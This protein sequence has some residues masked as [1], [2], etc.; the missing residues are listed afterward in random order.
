MRKEKDMFK[1]AFNTLKE[2]KFLFEELVK[3]DF[4]KKYKRTV[5]GMVWS[6]LGPLA[7]LGVM[8]LVFTHFFGRDIEH[9][10]IYILRKPAVRLFQRVHQSRH[11]IFIRKLSH[12]LQSQCSEVSVP[13]FQQ[14]F[15]T[16]QL[17]HQPRYTV[18]FL[19]DRRSRVHVEVR[20][21]AVSDMLPCS[22]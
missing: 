10:V 1:K 16:H 18:C 7:T 17:R 9:F 3:R 4:T 22:V 12:I 14:R 15:I 6:V 11:D 19:S 5:L 8:A 20:T 13:A 2:R 21:S